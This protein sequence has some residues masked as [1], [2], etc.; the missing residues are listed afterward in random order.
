MK[1]QGASLAAFT[2]NPDSYDPDKILDEIAETYFEPQSRGIFKQVMYKDY[3]DFNALASLK[4]GYAPPME[5]DFNAAAAAKDAQALGKLADTELTALDEALTKQELIRSGCNDAELGAGLFKVVNGDAP[6]F[7]KIAAD[8][9]KVR[10]A[11]NAKDSTELDK[12]TATFLKDL[13]EEK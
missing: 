3:Y 7:A 2:W 1:I 5:K 6:Y 4:A 10:D 9:K 8:L 11:V 13:K 12:D